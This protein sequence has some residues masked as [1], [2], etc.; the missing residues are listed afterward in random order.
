MAIPTVEECID[1]AQALLGD[2]SGVKFT[3]VACLFAFGRA[4]RELFAEMLSLEI[5]RIKNIATVTLAAGLTSLTPAA[6][7]I[8]DFGELVE[9]EERR[10]GSTEDFMPVDIVD[11]LQ[12]GEPYDVVGEVVWRLD[13]LYFHGPTT[14][15]E[16]RITY[17]ASGDAPVSGSVGVDDSR[18][19]FGARIASIVGPP[20][21]HLVDARE[22]RA[23]A[24]MYLRALIG[25]ML[26][27]MQTVKVQQS[28][29]RLGEDRVRAP[30]VRVI[31]AASS[32][33]SVPNVYS[34]LSGT[35]TGAIDGTNSV[36]YIGQA[37]N[38][39]AVYLNGARL[40]VGSH[41]I[42]GGNVVTFL[43]PYVPQFG[44]DIIVEAW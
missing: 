35:I 8:A 28:A 19:Y 3:D 23:E 22:L 33:G 20:K 42:H 27:N 37:S 25:P 9:V 31:A 18:N 43:A 39:I 40:T 30:F 1:D 26:K 12:Q 32:G 17:Y 7:G 13:A 16:L 34:S 41:Y 14:N 15:R 5:P 6:A 44:A 38:Q 4:Y 2:P 24:D 29:F 36:F 10:Q 11:K 21:G